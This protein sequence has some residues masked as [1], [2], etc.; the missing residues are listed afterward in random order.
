MRDVDK[1]LMQEVTCSK[2]S[3]ERI[4]ELISLG[5]DVNAVS[6]GES[7]L[8][9]AVFSI[10]LGADKKIVDLLIE[11]GADPAYVGDE[12][13]SALWEACRIVDV[14]LVSF[15]LERG[16]DPNTIGERYESLLDAVEEDRWISGSG[17]FDDWVYDDDGSN[18]NTELR[19][20]E[21][22][23]SLDAVI[24]LLKEHGAKR[25]VDMRTDVVSRWLVLFASNPTG[26]LTFGGHI[27]ID[28]LPGA[29]EGLIH[30]FRKWKSE[31]WDS[32]P[33][34]DWTSMPK[35]FVRAKHN[36]WG[37][38][39]GRTI[40]SIMPMEIEVEYVTVNAED[41]L[42]RIRNVDREIIDLELKTE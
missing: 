16:A 18:E 5:A 8:S 40:R 6:D 35:T 11:L 29:T 26:L 15:L 12:G 36:D 30:D 39:L 9:E 21:R 25:L 13:E 42:K 28:A 34:R 19:K 31:F 27:E 38:E 22:V 3:A 4:R 2:A 14:D 23:R 10:A 24:S 33:H 17:S 32:W 20:E 41:E 7:V 1:A 37:R